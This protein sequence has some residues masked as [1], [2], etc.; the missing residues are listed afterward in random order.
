MDSAATALNSLFSKVP[1]PGTRDGTSVADTESGQNIAQQADQ[2]S[3]KLNEAASSANAKVKE[4][5]SS[6]K[7]KA[8]DTT[9]GTTTSGTSASGATTSGSTSHQNAPSVDKVT[10]ETETVADQ[11]VAPAVEHDTIKREHE[12][13]ERDVVE[14]EIHK[15]HYHTTIQPLKDTEVQATEHKFEQAPTEFRSVDKDDGAAEAKVAEKLSGFQDTV[16]EEATKETHAQDETVVGEHV[17]H[18][19]HEI[20][21]P[22]IEKE[23]IQK[24]VTH[25]THPIKETVHEKSDDHGVTKAKA[26]SVEEFKHRLDGEAATEVNP[27]KPAP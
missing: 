5:A 14:K 23:V 17:H 2:A 13:L 25:V 21:Q 15:D 3:E 12:T 10:E 26:I 16:K 22:V 19:L 4:A 24:S 18:H 6:A 1:A 9:S 20:I 11:T 27:D 8:N 7:G